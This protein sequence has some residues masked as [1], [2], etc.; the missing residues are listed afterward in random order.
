M[1]AMPQIFFGPD[2][3]PLH[4]PEDVIN[5]LGKG[6]DHW[7]EDR[8]AYQAAYSWFTAKDL[9]PRIR[10]IL[11]GDPAFSTGVLERVVF[12]KKTRLDSF[13]RESQTDVLAYLKGSKGIT[14]LGVEAKVDETFGPLVREWNDYGTGKLRRL[15]GLLDRLEF[16]SKPIGGLRYQLFRRTA[17]TLI[18]AQEAGARDAAVI[19]QSFDAKQTGFDDFAAFAEAFGTPISGVGKLSHPKQLGTTA[20]RLGWTKNPIYIAKI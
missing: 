4:K 20:I 18:E 8:S 11:K 19:V 10:D 15:V 3:A 7:K 14:L 9:P 2:G 5:F 17:A 12:E 6:L 1:S 16:K 13:G